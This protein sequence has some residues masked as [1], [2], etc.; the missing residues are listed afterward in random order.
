MTVGFQD[1]IAPVARRVPERAAAALLGA[2][3][4]DAATTWYAIR[5]VPAIYERNPIASRIFAALGLEW[6]M[7][8]LGLWTVLMLIAAVEAGTYLLR[9]RTV[10]P[11]R[12]RRVLVYIGYVG[13]SLLFVAIAVYNYWVFS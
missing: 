7:L 9:M 12:T 6:G 1:A 4:L 8:L 11:D 5:Y 13:P 2:K 3:F 10:A